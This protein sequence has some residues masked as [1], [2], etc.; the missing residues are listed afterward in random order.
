M[1]LV[2]TIR[3][4][5]ITKPFSCKKNHCK[6]ISTYSHNAI[7]ACFNAAFKHSKLLN[8]LNLRLLVTNLQ[9]IV[10]ERDKKGLE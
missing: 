3:K 10:N 5:K 2:M 4:H 9:N 8:T 6:I 1:F 7:K